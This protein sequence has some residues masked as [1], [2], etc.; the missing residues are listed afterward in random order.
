MATHKYKS[1]KE[2]VKVTAI[3]FA[4][5]LIIIVLISRTPQTETRNYVEAMGGFVV[6]ISVLLFMLKSSSLICSKPLLH[7]LLESG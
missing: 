7:K 6:M 3:F 5:L 4:I 2:G 1:S